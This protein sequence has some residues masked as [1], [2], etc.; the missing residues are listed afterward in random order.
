VP[1]GGFGG[2]L[3]V[4]GVLFEVLIG[5]VLLFALLNLVISWINLN[6]QVE[7]KEGIIEFLQR[8]RSPAGE[9]QGVIKR[10]DDIYDFLEQL[11]GIMGNPFQMLAATHGAKILDRIFPPKI[12]P[13]P[14]D[15]EEQRSHGAISN[16]SSSQGAWPDEEVPPNQDVDEETR[17]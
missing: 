6:L 16:Q 2:R 10:I 14:N 3:G 1:H 13:I 15:S 5:F 17:E 8:Q 11:M 12:Q 7:I 9:I 4:F